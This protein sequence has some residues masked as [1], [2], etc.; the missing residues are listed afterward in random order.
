MKN[1][2]E[3]RSSLAHH[4]GSSSLYRH[5]LNKSCM[6]TEGVQDFAESA[7][8]G[9]YWLLDILVT[10]P[11]IL[12]AMRRENFVVVMLTVT[13]TAAHLTVRRD[14]HDP[15]LF[16]RAID[17]TDC[18]EGEWKFYFTDNVLMLPSEY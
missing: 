4:T 2:N 7:G 13:G 12:S 6:Y 14:T 15:I 11:L 10:E 5:G 3:L 1:A 16:Q 18:P 8:N 9:A 17:F